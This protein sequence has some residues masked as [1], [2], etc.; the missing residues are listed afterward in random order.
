LEE[1]LVNVEEEI[2]KFTIN[3]NASAVVSKEEKNKLNA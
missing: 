3:P 2:A 1:F